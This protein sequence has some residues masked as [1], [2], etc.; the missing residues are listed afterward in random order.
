MCRPQMSVCSECIS[1]HGGG[2]GDCGGSAVLFISECIY[3]W[4]CV[5]LW[6]RSSRAQCRLVGSTVS[7]HVRMSDVTTR[8]CR[9]SILVG[10][11]R[12]CGWVV[13]LCLCVHRRRDQR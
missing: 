7:T 12:H 8:A 3:A 11:R 1:S 4:K 2:G 9:S 13:L 6:P 5:Y 10:C